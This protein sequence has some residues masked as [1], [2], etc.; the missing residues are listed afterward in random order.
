MRKK[1]LYGNATNASEYWLAVIAHS[2]N[3]I[4]LGLSFRMEYKVTLLMGSGTYK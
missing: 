2:Q 4:I 1:W 3:A